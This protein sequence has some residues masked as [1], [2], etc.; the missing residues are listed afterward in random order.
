[1]IRS[2]SFNIQHGMTHCSTF[3]EQELQHLLIDKCWTVCRRLFF[4]KFPHSVYWA[5]SST[6]FDV[7]RA[8]FCVPL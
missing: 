2:A 4:Q 1:M 7:S 5:R 6:S 8:R 3:V